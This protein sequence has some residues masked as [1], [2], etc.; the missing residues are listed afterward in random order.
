MTC[1]MLVAVLGQLARCYEEQ[2]MFTE[3]E[4]FHVA[5][6]SLLNEKPEENKGEIAAGQTYGLLWTLYVFTLLLV[7]CSTT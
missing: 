4:N 3:A 5:E 2:E 6:L 7:C 1:D